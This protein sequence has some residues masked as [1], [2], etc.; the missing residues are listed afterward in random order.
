MLTSLSISTSALRHNVEQ[1]R[2]L[3]SQETKLAVVL[4]SNAYGHGLAET[5]SVVAPLADV[6]T[7]VTGAE[8]LFLR[9]L[10]HQERILVLS[11]LEEERI[12]DLLHAGIELP[13]YDLEQARLV[14]AAATEA[15][16]IARVHVK[17]DTG[18]SRVGILPKETA[19]FL[20][21]LRKFPGL[22]I[23]GAFSHFAD[24]EDP[25]CT[26]T[27]GQIAQFTKALTGSSSEGIER[28][29]ACTAALLLSPDAQF[30]LV[31]LGLGLYGLWPSD[32]VREVIQ[33]AQP[34]FT[35]QPV[36]TWT[37]HIIQL[38]DLPSGTSIGYGCSYTTTRPTK[39]AVLP[40]GYWDGYD[41]GLSNAGSVLI[42]G[43]RCPILGRVCM[44]LTMV[45]VTDIPHVTADEEVV[46]IGTQGNETISADNL[47]TQLS[48]INYEIVTRINPLLPR[49]LVA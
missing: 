35:L 18:A 29:M 2:N 20:A 15:H 41:R 26:Y 40:V 43:V 45:D 49:V 5:A 10:G 47:A 39:L 33:H 48:T 46:L 7:V 24:A 8:A 9:K 22:E 3:L 4:K 34:T 17:I 32:A 1:F 31:R 28:H 42:R 19:N 30:D 25:A 12:P 23:V 36:L 21:S 37:T 16:L 14:S 44:N 27:A 6:L 38:K 13:V 11:I